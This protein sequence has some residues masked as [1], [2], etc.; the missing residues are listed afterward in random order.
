M[1][2]SILELGQDKDSL[3]GFIIRYIFKFLNQEFTIISNLQYIW[4]VFG[5]FRSH[6]EALKMLN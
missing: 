3:D 2:G 6:T 4:P 5:I 1:C